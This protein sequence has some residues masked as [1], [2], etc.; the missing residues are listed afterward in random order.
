MTHGAPSVYFS[1][2][3]RALRCHRTYRIIWRPHLGGSRWRVTA[4]F[5]LHVNP[6]E[7]YALCEKMISSFLSL[8]VR[9]FCH[10]PLP[11]HRQTSKNRHPL[12]PRTNFGGPL[13]RPSSSSRLRRTR[14][15]LRRR[16]RLLLTP[17]W[18]MR[19]FP[20]TPLPSMVTSWPPSLRSS[21]LA[22]SVPRV[23]GPL[24]SCCLCGWVQEAIR[25][26]WL[27]G[28]ME[29]RSNST[30]TLTRTAPWSDARSSP[31]TSPRLWANSFRAS[32]SLPR[33]QASHCPSPYHLPH[34]CAAFVETWKAHRHW[35]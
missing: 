33:G 10:R 32:S 6:Q 25:N 5:W 8:P 31:S 14:V 11:Q 18:R 24:N 15:S 20:Q 19:M 17:F 34:R 30:S 12:T 26:F 4:R 9:H 13:T 29:P 27:M 3:S 35:P 2:Q 16:P 7:N 23:L 22:R 28:R 21:S 1:Y